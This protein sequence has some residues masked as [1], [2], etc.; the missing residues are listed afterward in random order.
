[1]IRLDKFRYFEETIRNILTE[2]YTTQYSDLELDMLQ[3][4]RETVA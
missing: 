2:I 3:K 1:M 4:S